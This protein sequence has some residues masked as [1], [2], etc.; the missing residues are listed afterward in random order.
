MKNKLYE[1]IA[2]IINPAI[3][4]I[5]EFEWENTD[6]YARYLAQTYFYTSHSVRLLGLALSRTE[7]SEKGLFEYFS[8][9]IGAEI[10][11][12]KLALSDL[13]NLGQDLEDHKESVY[14]RMLWES[15]YYKVEY[16]CSLSLLGYIL[17]LEILAIKRASV[18]C[19]RAAGEESTNFM[20]VHGEED[21]SHVEVAI[22]KIE[23]FDGN[24]I[25]KVLSNMKQTCAAYVAMLESIVNDSN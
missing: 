25:E 10:N 16:E 8:S 20:K 7:V 22:N 14:C 4:A 1:E 3:R 5:D 11:H 21:I 17:F 12:E 23:E 13:R 24:K 9:H 18:I 15:Q 19:K 6:F 2:V